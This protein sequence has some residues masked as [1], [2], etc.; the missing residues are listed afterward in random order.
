MRWAEQ[1]RIDWI[2]ARINQRRKIN[3]ADIME[4][5]GISLPQASHDL[6]TFIKLHPGVLKYDLKTK[7]YRKVTP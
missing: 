2:G 7:C 6:Q 4:K 3:R 1:Q 5:F